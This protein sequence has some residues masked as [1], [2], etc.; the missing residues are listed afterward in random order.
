MRLILLLAIIFIPAVYGESAQYAKLFLLSLGCLVFYRRSRSW[1]DPLVPGL[2]AA[3]LALSC[4]ATAFSPVTTWFEGFVGYDGPTPRHEGWITL[5]MV[6]VFAWYC[7]WNRQPID[8]DGNE[9]GPNVSFNS[10]GWTMLTLVLGMYLMRKTMGEDVLSEVVASPAGIGALA[11]L[12][13]PYLVSWIYFRGVGV[14]SLFGVLGIAISIDMMA[15]SGNRSALLGGVLGSVLVL[16][17]L[18]NRRHLSKLLLGLGL[19][20]IMVTFAV[21]CRGDMLYR[22]QRVNLDAIG[23]GPRTQLIESAI[24]VGVTPLGWGIDSQRYLIDRTPGDGMQANAYY[25]RFHIWPVDVL[26]T[27][28]II[29]LGIVLVALW[30][31]SAVVL[32]HRY[33]WYFAG[34]AGVLVSFLTRA[35]WN[36][37]TTQMMLL[38]AIA[39]SGI[40]TL[41]SFAPMGWTKPVKRSVWKGIAH[42]LTYCACIVAFLIQTSLLLGEA[43]A[44]DAKYRWSMQEDLPHIP[45]AE[46]WLAAKLNPYKLPER[47]KFYY[48]ATRVGSI[49]ERSGSKVLLSEV[50]RLDPRR[51][52]LEALL[53]IATDEGAANCEKALSAA[54]MER[55]LVR[56]RPISTLELTSP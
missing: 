31:L 51:Y 10:Y 4:L 7:F 11:S 36:P 25:D 52:D 54:Y 34:F 23:H 5:L 33:R 2:G 38:A 48:I 24:Q 8:Q 45:L 13:T 3:L 19:G 37:P 16:L 1:R 56:A 20:I 14:G 46:G 49:K 6:F 12:A 50:L 17:L 22:L 40:L 39:A 30:R 42:G 26:M 9:I 35:I 15:R 43:L 55:N 47:V 27:T 28:G 18:V 44:W 41:N 21:C 53:W 32:D 29:G